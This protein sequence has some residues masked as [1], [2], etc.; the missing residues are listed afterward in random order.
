MGRIIRV[1]YAVASERLMVRVTV[2]F[3]LFVTSEYAAWIGMLVYAYQNGGATASGL[4]A[5]AQLIPGVF[6][7]PVVAGVADRR[8]PTAL[9]VAGYLVQTIGL[10]GVAVA[11]W[12]GAAPILAYAFAVVATTAM[13]AI[14]PAQFTLLPALARDAS[15]LTAANVVAGWAESGGIVVGSLLAALFLGGGHIDWLFALM[16]ASEITAAYLVFQAKVPG[17]AVAED[18]EYGSGLAE[19]M[20]GV[21]TAA[22]DSR[23]RLLVGILA[24]QYVVEGALDVLLVVIAVEVLGR[25]EAW[26][27]YLNTAYGL[28]GVAAGLITAH[29]IWQRLGGVIAIAIATSAVALV[30]TAFS[31]VAFVTAGLLWLFGAGRAVLSVSVTCVLQRVVPPSAVGRVFG[32]VEGLSNAGLAVGAGLAPLLIHLGGRRIAVVVVACLLPITAAVGLSTLRHLDEAASV[33]LVEVALLRSLPHFAEM[34]ASA[35]EVLAGVAERVTAT[36]GEVIITQ[37]ED[38]DRFYAIVDGVVAASVDGQ[39]R[40]HLGRGSGFGEIALLRRTSRTATIR[41]V[42]PSTLLALDS[43]SFLAAISGH[44]PTRRRAESVAADWS[45]ADAKRS[46]F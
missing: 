43:A 22:R 37:G 30:L 38:A 31:R 17:I 10:A 19:W 33:P 3:G 45:E 41:A 6:L 23:S 2:A 9:L 4:V 32:L 46:A 11:L 20:V 34:P 35:L 27:G 28:G 39:P 16:A 40:G 15:Q 44:A 26:V 8:S 12:A 42:E 13:V 29:L 5:V 36:A 21:R 18:E 25:S 24:V 14:R 1:A 7:A